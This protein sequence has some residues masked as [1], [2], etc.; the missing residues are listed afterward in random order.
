MK[1]THFQEFFKNK[2]IVFLSIFTNAIAIALSFIIG[3][4]Y[5][6]YKKESYLSEEGEANLKWHDYII[7][8]LL[9]I[10]TALTAYFI[11]F[12][13]SGYLPMSRIRFV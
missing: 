12:I 4:F 13:V 1:I 2:K 3:I 7:T 10:S 6:T 5:T 8:L 9:S 11:V